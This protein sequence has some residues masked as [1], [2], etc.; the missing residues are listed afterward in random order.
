[1]EVI[2]NNLA[3]VNTPAFKRDLALFRARFA[4]EIEQ[5]GD[6]PGSGSINDIGGGV[7]VDQ[8][9]TDFQLGPMQHTGTQTDFAIKGSGFFLVNKDGNEFLTRAGNFQVMADGDLVT[10]DGYPVLDDTRRPINIDPQL[11]PWMFAA[12]GAI[13]QAGVRTPL[14]LV[15]PESLGDLAKAGENLFRPL[16][17]VNALPVESR[18][19]AQGFLEQSAVRPT[20]EM[21]G[22]IEASRAFEANVQLIKHQ[23]SMIGNLVGRVLKG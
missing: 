13:L 20:V 23:D 1:M 14:A 16:G 12:D 4:E 18:N 5:G 8:T 7:L 17:R 15:Q 2:S 9:V 19:V 22:L 21:M 3:N 10:V 11:G 6:F